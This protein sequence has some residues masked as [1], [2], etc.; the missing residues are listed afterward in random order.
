MLSAIKHLYYDKCFI[1][2]SEKESN[3]S[4]RWAV[5]FQ[6][7]AVLVPMRLAPTACAVVCSPSGGGYHGRLFTA[8]RGFYNFS[9]VLLSSLFSFL[10]FLLSFHPA[11]HMK[12]VEYMELG[13]AA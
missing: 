10:L 12:N 11:K 1:K 7:L 13:Y 9:V 3:F 4:P 5:L 8:F 2:C 6:P